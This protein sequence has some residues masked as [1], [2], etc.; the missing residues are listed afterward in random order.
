MQHFLI[1]CT[2]SK[3]TCRYFSK[4]CFINMVYL[5]KLSNSYFKT[6]FVRQI[7]YK[8]SQ[9][10]SFSTIDSKLSHCDRIL[11]KNIS[12]I[13]SEI[14]PENAKVPA[15]TKSFRL[16]I[17]TRREKKLVGDGWTEL[18]EKN[19]KLVAMTYEFPGDAE[20]AFY[21]GLG[22]SEKG[23]DYISCAIIG[24]EQAMLL[25]PNIYEQN[26]KERI[27]ALLES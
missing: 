1:D 11:L 24:F 12:G 15:S 17:K 23:K 21:K 14:L 9:F 2:H 18:S 19:K 10:V 26:C 25:D 16:R 20:I 13:Q 4:V 3:F 27:K 8:Q 6:L 5:I 22:Y 7:R